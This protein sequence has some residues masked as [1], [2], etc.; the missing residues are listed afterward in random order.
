MPCSRWSAPSQKSPSQTATT[1]ARLVSSAM[2][3]PLPLCWHFY[4]HIVENG[5]ARIKL[6]TTSAAQRRPHPGRFFSFAGKDL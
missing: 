4:L 6:F 1:H 2:A 3:A 5:L